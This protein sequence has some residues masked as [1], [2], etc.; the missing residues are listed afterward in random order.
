MKVVFNCAYFSFHKDYIFNIKNELEKRGYIGIITESK[1]DC[2]LS[3]IQIEDN[4]IDKHSD[5]DFTILP[6]EACRKIGGKGI[7][8]N[9]AI[10]IIPHN[11]FYYTYD[12]K[13]KINKNCD[14]IFTS[15][16]SVEDMYISIG[17]DKPIKIV[18]I[19]KLDNIF[20]LNKKY[21]L[22]APTGKWKKKM[23]SENIVDIDR[24]KNYDNVI[25]LGHPN[26]DGDNKNITDYLKESKIVI[27]DYSSV[28]LESIILNI[29]TIL[30]DK[31]YWDNIDDEF[32]CNEAR[33]ASIRVTNMEQL[34]R[35]IEKYNKDPTYLEDKRIRYGELLSEYQNIASKKFVDELYKLL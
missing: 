24:L 15:S 18:G 26:D 35:A 9:H 19:P 31:P 5:A 8:I 2:N 33:N 30:I 25:I 29:P 4:Y 21:I 34:I 12:Y 32:I 17:L 16:Q 10:P 1:D 7:Y 6:D 13:E 11:S 3:A 20:P 22:Y 14:Y 28:G 27:S 23:N